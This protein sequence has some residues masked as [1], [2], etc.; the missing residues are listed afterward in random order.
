MEPAPFRSLP[1]EF[2]EFNA[3]S[4]ESGRDLLLIRTGRGVRTHRVREASLFVP[5]AFAVT[6]DN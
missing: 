1:Y 4:T 3:F 6:S 5:N 2:G